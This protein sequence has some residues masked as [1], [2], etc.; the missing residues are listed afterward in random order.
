MTKYPLRLEPYV[1][2]V[3]WGGRWLANKLGRKGA[4]GAKLGESW[5]AYSNSIITNGA[6][7]GKKIAELFETYGTALFGA[8][9][10][11]YPKF[12]LLVKFI[13]A[14]QNLSVQVHPDDA[15]AQRLENY[16][17][18]K[19]EFWYVI[20]AE[21]GA[22]ICY[23]LNNTPA[24]R[25]DL[26]EAIRHNDLLRYVQRSP[27]KK[28]DVL[29]LPAGIVHALTEGVVVYELQQDC[30]I[31]YRL[32]DWGR[33]EREMHVEKGVQ[34]INLDYRNF[35]VTHAESISYKGYHAA[36]LVACDYF[37]A[38]LWQVEKQA[39]LKAAAES[40]TVL[41]VLGGKGELSSPSSEFV[42]QPLNKGDTVLIPSEVDYLLTPKIT[43]HPL[44]VIG[45]WL[46]TRN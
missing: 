37:T 17:F 44:E 11:R 28:G 7:S 10:M 20:K 24:T 43:S 35:K 13:D 30:D 39:Q 42:A 26:A 36:E 38:T 27:V 46:E 21:K 4:E 8:A 29:F 12:P 33:T 23:S 6:F 1:K 5:E 45:C 14:H 18:G 15:M 16:P 3:V 2:E 9:A 34:A 22:E 19:T 31:T 41:T 25:E 32:Y 40:F